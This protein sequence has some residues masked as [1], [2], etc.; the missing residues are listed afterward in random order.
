MGTRGDVD[1]E[2]MTET[3][4]RSRSEVATRNAT[5]GE[6][7]LSP[8]SGVFQLRGVNFEMKETPEGDKGILGTKRAYRTY[9]MCLGEFR[10]SCWG[11]NIGRHVNFRDIWRGWRGSSQIRPEPKPHINV[12]TIA[13]FMYSGACHRCGETKRRAGINRWPERAT[14]FDQSSLVHR[15]H[16]YGYF[17]SSRRIKT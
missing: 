9:H 2:T 17:C 6:V 4:L 10:C 14:S 3:P 5:A 16:N 12:D 11:V 1:L 7:Y 15:H 13:S 8:G